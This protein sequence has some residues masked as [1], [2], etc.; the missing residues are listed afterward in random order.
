MSGA[1]FAICSELL[2]AWNTHSTH[3][4]RPLGDFDLA[5]RTH[6]LVFDLW[7]ASTRILIVFRS[8]LWLYHLIVRHQR[9]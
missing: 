4:F 6:R 2:G 1:P 8:D 5:G 9:L 7:H 3:V